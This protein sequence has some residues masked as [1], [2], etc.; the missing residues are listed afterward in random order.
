[1]IYIKLYKHRMRATGG[2]ILINVLFG[3]NAGNVKKHF[4]DFRTLHTKHENSEKH[5]FSKH[6]RFSNPFG[7]EIKIIMFI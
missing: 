2:G 3:G 1:M 6:D 7:N 4:E 5:P